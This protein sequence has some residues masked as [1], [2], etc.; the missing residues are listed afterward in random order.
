MN[1][2]MT[3]KWM[4]IGAHLGLAAGLMLF[5][6]VGAKAAATMAG[7]EE[8]Q[9]PAEGNGF[10][11]DDDARSEAEQDARDREQAKKDAEAD[12]QDRMQ[13]LYDD[14]RGYLDEGS[15]GD[16]VRAFAQLVQMKGPQTDAAMYWLAYAENKQGKRD[17][18]LSTIGD[19]KKAYPQSKWTK[20]AEALAIEIR[21]GTGAKTNPDTVGDDELKLLALQGLMNSDPSKGIPLIEK[22]LNSSA[23]PAVKSKALFVLA[24]SGSPQAADILGRVA[25]GKSNPELQRKAVEY[26]GIFGGERSEKTLAEVY[27]AATD[28][29]LKRAVL[30][31]Y[32][33]SGNK[34]A[35]F[36]AAKSEKNDDLKREA[37]KQLGLVGGESEL[38]QLYNANSSVEVRREILQAFF[39]AGDSKRLVQAALNEK[40]PDLRRAAIKNLGLVGGADA[41]DALKTIYQR[42]TD[43]SLKEEVLNAYFL[44]GN[45]TALVAI[46][47]SEKDP[48]LRKKAVE[49]L[50]LIGDKTATDYMMEILQK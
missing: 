4:K 44:E 33:I 27:G 29:N 37:I 5:P 43:R 39:L 35:L 25:L 32:M 30:K 10:V 46:A 49:K 22:V 15:Y 17:A 21:G 19:L 31:S 42:E 12:R 38:E 7:A 45:S 18:A 3:E 26:L 34:Q 36:N 1:G 14:G 24:Q 20:D 8:L 11:A 9:L 13:E 41:S 48:E 16:A 50:S 6:A 47:K 2:R 23:S 28:P 40:D